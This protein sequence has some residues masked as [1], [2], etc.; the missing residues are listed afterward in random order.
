MQIRNIYIYS[1]GFNCD[2]CY[3]NNENFKN[4]GIATINYLQRLN[5]SFVTNNIDSNTSCKHE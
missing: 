4:S 3:N 1:N 5:V 2:K